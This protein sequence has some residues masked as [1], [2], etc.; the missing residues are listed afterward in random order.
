MTAASDIRQMLFDLRVEHAR[1]I[2]RPNWDF[3]GDVAVSVRQGKVAPALAELLFAAYDRQNG[4][5]LRNALYPQPV[6]VIDEDA[7]DTWPGQHFWDVKSLHAIG[8]GPRGSRLEFAYRLNM[9]YMSG[10]GTWSHSAGFAELAAGKP[11]FH[12]G[13]NWPDRWGQSLGSLLPLQ[14]RRIAETAREY[15]TGWSSWARTGKTVEARTDWESR[16]SFRFDYYAFWIAIDAHS[17]FIR[18]LAGAWQEHE[19]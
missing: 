2:D 16:V 7:F 11:E 17:E 14:Y 5:L 3:V 4:S 13:A 12:I 15:S 1:S 19:G 10:M 9:P 6:N 8:P 18:D